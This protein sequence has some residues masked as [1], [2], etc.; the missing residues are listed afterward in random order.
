MG[1]LTPR[2]FNIARGNAGL[3]GAAD[4]I[5]AQARGANNAA[6]HEFTRRNSAQPGA[7][8][9]PVPQ[10]EELPTDPQFDDVVLL[11]HFDGAD[12]GTTA[13][14]ITG[15]HTPV[16]LNDAQL[17]TA[18]QKFGTA[19]LL[20]DGVND[21]FSVPWSADFN[22]GTGDFC[23]ETW[24]RFG[25]SEM[26]A[27][28][29][30]FGV[31]NTGFNDRVWA[32]DYNVSFDRLIFYYST[33]GANTIGNV[34][35]QLGTDGL[36]VAELFDG[37]FHHVA[38]IRSGSNIYMHVDGLPGGGVDTTN[39]TFRASSGPGGTPIL[40]GGVG[41]NSIIVSDFAGH[42]DDL[43][44]TKGSSRYTPGVAFAPPTEAF[45]D[46]GSA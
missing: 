36:S 19:S 27:S 25:T 13:T 12:G 2:S 10:E 9:G 14:D 37:N 33:T 15:R 44:I 42:F 21:A 45:P 18:F 17:D 22:F 26:V 32:L 28:A 20:T 41:S 39:P 23:I 5:G 4:M 24:I 6:A 11:V 43:R 35:F 8:S 30:M 40:L 46:S 38:I 16:F 31:W 29:S 3:V 7:A 34:T 1:K